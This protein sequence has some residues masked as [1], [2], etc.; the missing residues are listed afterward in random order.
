MT[1]AELYQWAYV[2][3]WGEH[4]LAQLEEKLRSYVFVPYDHEL[5]K[6]WASICA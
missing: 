1:V 3:N 2:R 6:Q 5:C 4:K